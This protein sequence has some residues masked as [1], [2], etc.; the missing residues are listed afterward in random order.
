MSTYGIR[1]NGASEPSSGWQYLAAIWGHTKFAK[2][3]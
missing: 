3:R 1:K 2:K